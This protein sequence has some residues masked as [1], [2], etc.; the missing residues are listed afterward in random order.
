MCERAINGLQRAL[1]LLFGLPD[2][3]DVVR[4]RVEFRRRCRSDG[5]VVRRALARK[6]QKQFRE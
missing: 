4:E 3:R 5:S 1:D 2:L 6:M